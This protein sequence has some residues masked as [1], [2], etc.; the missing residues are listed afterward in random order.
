MLANNQPRVIDRV[1]ALRKTIK[2]VF[3]STFNSEAKSHLNNT[4]HRTEE[5]KMAVMIMEIVGQ[6]F[7]TNRFYPTMSGVLKSINYYPV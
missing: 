6:N 4:A 3:A 7:S 2:L 5:E 1:K